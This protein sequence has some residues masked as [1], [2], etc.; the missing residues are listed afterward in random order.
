MVQGR[1]VRFIKNAY[2]NILGNGDEC[3]L[4]IS[5]FPLSLLSQKMMRTS[6]ASV[7]PLC[8]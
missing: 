1:K 6:T 3:V 2:D 8:I 7:V 4:L 5:S